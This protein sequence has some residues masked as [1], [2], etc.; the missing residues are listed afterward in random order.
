MARSGSVARH[1]P[2]RRGSGGGGPRRR[3]HANAGTELLLPLA[4]EVG[5]IGI[6][7]TDL[8]RKRTRFSPELCTILGLPVGTEMPYA[9]A[10]QLIDERDRHTIQARVHAART[11]TDRGKWSGLCR[12]RRADGKLRWVSVCGRRTYR[13]TAGG[14]LPVRSIGTVVDVTDLKET[15]TALR[16]SELR[17]RLALDAAQMGTFEADIEANA[18]RIDAQEARLLG[19]PEETRMVSVE[20]MRKRIPLEDLTASD[21]KQARMT[22]RREAYHHEFRLVM[23]D[24]SE[25]WLSAHADVRSGRI[26]GV[27]FDVTQ[28]KRAETALRDREAR[29]RIATEAAALGVFEWDPVTDCT[30][31]ENDRMYRIFGRTR[32][33]GPLNKQEFVADYLHPSD[34]RG[35]EAAVTQAMRTGHLHVV[36][37]IRRKN[38]ARRWLQIDGKVE[39]ES[40]SAPKRL[41]GVVADITARK[42]LQEAE[43]KLPGRILYAQEEERRSIAQELHDSTVQHLVAASL[44]LTTLKARST[45]RDQP[46][47]DDLEQVLG[48]AMKELRTFS[49]LMHPPALKAVGLFT[50][51]QRYVEGFA[52]RSGLRVTLR[53][54]WT[55]QDL[56]PGV[57]RSIFRIVQEGL[58]NAYR[59]ASASAV[60]VQLRH[61]GGTLHIIV[62]DNGIGLDAKQ[63]PGELRPKRLGAGIRGIEMRV[64]R[65]GGRLRLSRPLAGGTRLHAVL[66]IDRTQ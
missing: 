56:P 54:D 52:E 50:S 36:C 21:E 49:Y 28:S 32:A 62:T 9:E 27:N 4:V 41:I 65:L 33:E 38:G 35:Y 3:R 10:W 63:K 6:F 25:R 46:L 58:S 7:E 23:P 61:I 22:Q 16:E 48:Q 59:H 29:L 34:A 44:L 26:F 47:W 51:L 31:W 24:G 30:T 20:D 12:V 57:Q 5:G 64:K 2:R 11:T 39:K 14:L 8:E 40:A 17:L 60:F 19:L 13:E 43:Q 45:T 1:P 55:R 37:R 18:A 42:R 53:L 66:P 15:E